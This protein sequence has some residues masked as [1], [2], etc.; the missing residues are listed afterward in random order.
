MVVEKAA[1]WEIGAMLLAEIVHF[2]CEMASLAVKKV[3]LS[4]ATGCPVEAMTRR[5][6]NSKRCSSWIGSWISAAG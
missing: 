3:G 5:S 4:G 2:S 1:F 6:S